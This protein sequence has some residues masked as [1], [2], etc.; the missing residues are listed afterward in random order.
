M[1][2]KRS[3]EAD[4]QEPVKQ[5]PAAH[6][7]G[8]HDVAE[9]NSDFVQFS[10]PHLK[11]WRGLIAKSA[12]G[13]QILMFLVERMGRTNN[14]VVCSYAVLTEITGYSR[15]SVANAIKVLKTDNWIEAVRVGNSTAYCVNERVVWQAARGQRKYAMFSATVIASESEQERDFIE[16]NKEDLKRIPHVG[17]NELATMSDEPLPPPDQVEMEI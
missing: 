1:S 4:S 10:K 8:E 6:S 15:R 9:R 5:A 16:K 13:A 7:P 14:A 2:A 12:L 17:V 3:I 11:N